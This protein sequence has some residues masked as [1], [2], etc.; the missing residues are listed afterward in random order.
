[1]SASKS[2]ALVVECMAVMTPDELTALAA[3][4]DVQTAQRR[5]SCN[6]G[7]VLCRTCGMAAAD[8]RSAYCS[9]GIHCPTVSGAYPEAPEP[10]PIDVRHDL[11]G[12][13]APCPRAIASPL[14]PRNEDWAVISALEDDPREPTAPRPRDTMPCAPPPLSGPGEVPPLAGL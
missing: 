1:M 14:P 4:V 8:P 10:A 3:A 13:S 9:N 5:Y 2:R 6:T 12:E 7:P 11:E